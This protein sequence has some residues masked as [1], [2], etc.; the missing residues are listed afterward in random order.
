MVD[1]WKQ[2]VRRFLHCFSLLLCVAALVANLCGAKET[3]ADEITFPVSPT[4]LVEGKFERSEGIAFNGEGDLFVTANR[5]LWV[6]AKSGEV[7]KVA[8][9]YSNLGLAPIGERDI[10]VADFGPTNIFRDGENDD[11]IV[12]R[13]SPEGEKRIVAIGIDDPNFI[14]V[15][16]D[17]TLLVSDDGINHI[18]KVDSEGVATL[19]TDQINHPNGMVLYLDGTSLY[20]A[21]IFQRI[22]PIVPDNRVWRIALEKGMPVGSAEMVANPGKGGHDGLAMDSKGRIYVAGNGEGKIWRIDQAT[23]E[24]ILI[25][26]NMPGVASF[27]F[28]EGEFDHYA[29]YAT[30]T[31]FGTVWRVDVGI[32]GAPLV[33]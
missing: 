19:Y 15:M 20:V 3:P 31:R 30:S 9:L 10:L 23:G 22:N 21:Q 2:S 24:S 12:W 17:K 13:V 26:E 7:T 8:D 16:E 5:A 29:I 4:I 32:G 11:G 6:V 1:M 27:A 25:A 14:L 33:R 28:G 18:Y